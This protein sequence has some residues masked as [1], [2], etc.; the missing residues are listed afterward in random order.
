M[1]VSDLVAAIGGTLGLF[2]GM[3]FMSFFEVFELAFTLVYSG[4]DSLVVKKKKKNEVQP[5]NC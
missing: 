3:S 1:E 4:V 2:L 5:A